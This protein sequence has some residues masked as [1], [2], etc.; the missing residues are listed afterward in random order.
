M[1]T[2]IQQK[3]EA[4]EDIDNS[5]L[6]KKQRALWL[7]IDAKGAYSNQRKHRL[8]NT[9]FDNFDSSPK[10]VDKLDISHLWGGDLQI[11]NFSSQ[12]PLPQQPNVIPSK[13]TDRDFQQ[14]SD[15]LDIEWSPKNLQELQS[16]KFEI[17]EFDIYD[18]GLEALQN[19]EES[20]RITDAVQNW[21]EE[22][23]RVKLVQVFA[24]LDSSFSGV[25]E[26][27]LEYLRDEYHKTPIVVYG[28]CNGQG[29]QTLAYN[30]S[31]SIFGWSEYASMVVP[32]DAHNFKSNFVNCRLGCNY[33]TSYVLASNVEALSAPMRRSSVN[34]H[35]Y[36]YVNSLV[37][38]NKLKVVSNGFS[39]PF[40]PY[41]MSPQKLF[42]TKGLNFTSDLSFSVLKKVENL[43]RSR[44]QHLV[45]RGCD[46]FVG[47]AIQ[48]Q[49]DFDNPSKI[50]KNVSILY[51]ARNLE[52]LMEIY[53]LNNSPSTTSN[54]FAFSP[55]LICC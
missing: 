21:Q 6:W 32:M 16:V 24:D 44:S 4:N 33:Q 25:A 17:E 19:Q 10:K 48:L 28:A 35:P 46:S 45:V 14:W 12:D 53:C 26:K 18:K 27:V 54:W 34:F 2:P 40:P 43:D 8:R 29:S 52:R 36:A 7:S 13:P 38:T 51:E 22:C 1:L 11:Y 42:A 49:Q 41:A 5:A 15:Y 3:A 37:L 31:R 55:S 47:G 9:A 50:E 39:M 30:K 20:R 23:D